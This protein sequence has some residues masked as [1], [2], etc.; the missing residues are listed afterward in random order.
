MGTAIFIVGPESS[1]T[2]MLTEAFI[3]VGCYGDSEINQ[4]MDDYN[5]TENLIVFRRS[6]PHGGN[7]PDIA[8]IVKNMKDYRVIPILILRDKEITIKS[9]LRAGHVLTEE[10]SRHNIEFAIPYA[11]RHFAAVGLIPLV[12]IYEAFVESKDLRRLF[13]TS[14]ALM[15]PKME[16]RNENFKYKLP[17][18]L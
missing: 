12:I 11:Y 10:E 14:L 15:E 9:Q 3:N 4:R 7:W 8:S 5:F 16:F 17:Y 1:G 6:L 13:F 18:K 2:R